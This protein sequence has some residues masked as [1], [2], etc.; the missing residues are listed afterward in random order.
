MNDLVVASESMEN[1]SRTEAKATPAPMPRT[2]KRSFPERD[3]STP[4]AT[5][6]SSEK[7]GMDA[8]SI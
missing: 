1:T 3:L 8:L 4:V 6:M 2:Q 5:P 7:V